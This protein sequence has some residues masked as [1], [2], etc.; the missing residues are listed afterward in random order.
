MRECVLV[1]VCL[2]VFLF[3]HSCIS[4]IV[5]SISGALHWTGGEEERGTYPAFLWVFIHLLLPD[6]TTAHVTWLMPEA[7]NSWGLK[8]R[9]GRTPVCHLKWD[10]TYRVVSS[11]SMNSTCLLLGQPQMISPS[12]PI[13]AHPAVMSLCSAVWSPSRTCGAQTWSGLWRGWP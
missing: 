9:W 4:C 2:C 5:L 6:N 12:K 11:Y 3:W 1:C 7:S 13:G 8:T 10:E